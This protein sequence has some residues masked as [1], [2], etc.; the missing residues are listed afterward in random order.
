M[1][2][3]IVGVVL[4]LLQ[5]CSYMGNFLNTG[6]IAGGFSILNFRM[7]DSFGQLLYDI[8]FTLSAN[9]FIIIGVVFVI[10]GY[11]MYKK[12]IDKSDD[13]DNSKIAYDYKVYEP[14]KNAADKPKLHKGVKVFFFVLFISG[15]VGYSLYTSYVINDLS[16]TIILKDEKI[17]ELSSEM[18][19]IKYDLNWY[20]FNV[21]L[22]TD[23]GECYHE[24]GCHYI[25]DSTVTINAVNYAEYLGYRPCS[26]CKQFLK[27]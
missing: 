11:K 13:P 21:A 7:G 19:S 4:I 9:L 25:E 12:K 10:I 2:L 16:E 6:S 26:Y 18:R 24:I 17:V 15:I 14:H 3:M 20:N 8:V 22:T 5:V 1:E 23:T 27:N